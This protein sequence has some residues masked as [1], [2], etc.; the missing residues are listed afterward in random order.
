MGGNP[1]ENVKDKGFWDGGSEAHSSNG[2]SSG[3]SSGFPGKRKPKTVGVKT[4]IDAP[5]KPVNPQKR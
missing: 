3:K 5:A 2:Q 4:D 1:R